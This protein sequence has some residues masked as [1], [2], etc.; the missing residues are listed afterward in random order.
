MAHRRRRES[1][2]ASSKRKVESDAWCLSPRGING[3]GDGANRGVVSQKTAERGIG[4]AQWRYGWC[5]CALVGCVVC[6]CACVLSMQKRC[7]VQVAVLLPRVCSEEWWK[8]DR[9]RPRWATG[10]VRPRATAPESTMSVQESGGDVFL[11]P[12]TAL[13]KGREGPTRRR[14]GAG[15]ELRGSLGGHVDG[16]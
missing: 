11:S 15:R 5:C 14:A 16:C 3:G 1:P 6:S 13:G 12:L 4:G 2:A 9:R 8:V 7:G 10:E